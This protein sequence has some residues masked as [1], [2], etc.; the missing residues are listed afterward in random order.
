VGSPDDVRL[1][2]PID[3]ETNEDFTNL[4]PYGIKAEVIRCLVRLVIETQKNIEEDGLKIYIIDHIVRGECELN[5]K[6]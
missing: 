3:W 1:S 4:M 2:I 6:S 5:I